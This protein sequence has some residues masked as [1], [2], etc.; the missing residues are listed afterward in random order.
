M[1]IAFFEPFQKLFTDLR[2]AHRYLHQQVANIVAES[3]CIL[4]GLIDK[5]PDDNHSLAEHLKIIHTPGK[6]VSEDMI[7]ALVKFSKCCIKVHI[8]H[9]ELLICQPLNSIVSN[10]SVNIAFYEPGHYRAV[11][12]IDNACNK[13]DMQLD[14]ISTFIYRSFSSS[15]SLRMPP[16]VLTSSSVSSVKTFSSSSLRAPPSVPTSLL[17]SSRTPPGVPKS[18]SV[19][20]CVPPG[21]PTFASHDGDL[22]NS[23]V[24][25][26]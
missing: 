13:S 3:G 15:V 22:I 11:L 7:I 23:P 21:M 5:S 25:E 20:S 10:C 8:A 26:N 24:Q 16:G 2:T 18:L 9:S 19:S 14:N 6:A 17:A 4:D 1:G 12:P